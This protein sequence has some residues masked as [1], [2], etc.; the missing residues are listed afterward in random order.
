M[1]WTRAGWGIGVVILVLGTGVSRMVAE[2]ATKAQPLPAAFVPGELR[3][4][5]GLPGRVRA[6]IERA[7]E[8]SRMR[9]GYRYGSCDPAAGGM[10]CSGTIHRLLRDL[11]FADVP[12][13]SDGIY[14][15]VWELSRM[16]PV[17]SH[18]IE[19]FEL[20]ELRPGDLMFW[21]GTYKVDREVPITHVM[22]YLGVRDSDGRRVMFGASDGRTSGGVSSFGVGA[23]DFVLP[24]P[25]PNGA[26]SRFVGYGPIPGIR[27]SVSP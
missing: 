16:H 9:L 26:G 6:V 23:F 18:S 17:V 5:D 20:K 4:F 13:Q 1:R 8:L 3:G 11:G 7:S 10:D 15:W 19:S 25:T 24:K 21:T 14:R 12:R 27:E 22:L 2:D